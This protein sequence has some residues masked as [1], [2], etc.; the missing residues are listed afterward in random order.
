MN[1]VM[2]SKSTKFL[3]SIKSINDSKEIIKIQNLTQEKKNRL[4]SAINYFLLQEILGFYWKGIKN[5]NFYLVQSLKPYK[6]KLPLKINLFDFLG[7]PKV[8]RRII[9]LIF[10]IVPDLIINILKL[11]GGIKNVSTK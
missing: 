3:D 8:F 9:L 5:K 2:H 7:N 1:S 4:D 11:L 6:N 10:N